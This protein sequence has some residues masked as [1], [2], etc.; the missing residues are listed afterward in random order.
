MS[1]F[2]TRQPQNHK[3]NRFTEGSISI[4]QKKLYCHGCCCVLSSLY[5]RAHPL[6]KLRRVLCTW[7]NLCWEL[8]THLVHYSRGER[9]KTENKSKRASINLHQLLFQ[10]P[11]A[12]GRPLCTLLSLS[13]IT[14]Y[15]KFWPRASFSLWWFTFVLVP[16]TLFLVDW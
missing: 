6:A 4:I 12:M 10:S 8:T 13:V 7:R 3:D 11:V 9:V 16:S 5:E 1:L 2:T 15:C 14:V